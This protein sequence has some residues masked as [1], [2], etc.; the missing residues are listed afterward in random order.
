MADAARELVVAGV[1]LEAVN[2]VPRDAGVRVRLDP[3]VKPPRVDP[4]SGVRPARKPR[5]CPRPDEPN[6]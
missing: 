6:P 2:G 3:D 5:C 1:V 4:D